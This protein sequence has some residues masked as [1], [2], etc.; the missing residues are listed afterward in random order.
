MFLK[1]ENSLMIFVHLISFNFRRFRILFDQFTR[2]RQLKSDFAICFDD[3]TKFDK[4]KK[5]EEKENDLI[6]ESMIV[7]VAHKTNQH[8]TQDFECMSDLF[9]IQQNSKLAR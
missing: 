3:E 5:N 9:K 6:F 8:K 7:V 4:G 2:M 1:L